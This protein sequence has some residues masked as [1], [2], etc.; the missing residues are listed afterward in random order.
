[1]I[2]LAWEV[3]KYRFYN[4]IKLFWLNLRGVTVIVLW[5]QLAVSEDYPVGIAVVIFAPDGLTVAIAPD[6]VVVFVS[7]L[8][9]C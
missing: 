8:P 5:G 1:M 6:G 7:Y 9:W 3:L 2:V 4:I